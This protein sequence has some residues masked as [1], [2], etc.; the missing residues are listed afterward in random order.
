MITSMDVEQL[1]EIAESFVSAIEEAKY[2]FSFKDRMSRYPKG[3]C[4]DA[5]DLFAHFLSEKYGIITTRIDGA[6]YADDP[7]DNDWHTW[8]EVD[9]YVVDL[10]AYQYM[11]YDNIYVGEYDSFHKR[12]EIQKQKY[13]GFYDLG[14]DCWERMQ[15]LYDQIV[16]KM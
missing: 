8:L 14:Q 2:N 3:C 9:G 13:R 1:Q 16:E 4:D 12:Y 15:G 6:Y 7:E 10:T 5:T 11:E